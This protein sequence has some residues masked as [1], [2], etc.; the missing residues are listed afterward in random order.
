VTNRTGRVLDVLDRRGEPVIR[1]GPDATWVN[2]ASPAYYAEHPVHDSPDAAAQPPRWVLASRDRSWGW[3]DPRIQPEAAVADGGWHIDMRLGGQLLTVSG[4]FRP[5]AEPRGYW[6]PALLTRAE[7]APKVEAAIVP[8]PVPAL[9]IDNGGDEPVTIIGSHGE[10]F[11]RIGPDGVFANALSPTW[12]QS[13]RAPETAS[14][15]VPARGR[16]AV[17]WTKISTGSR[18]TWLEWRA[19]GPDDRA[20]R[21]A[22][23]WRIP[24][25]IGDKPVPLRG[26]SDWIEMAAPRP[27]LAKAETRAP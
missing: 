13:G 27:A 19:R 12:L 23:P 17:R 8:G 21:M 25:L 11:L 14:P 3:F 16:Q 6:R 22:M 2:A 7:I 1:I 24:L 18:Y 5:H 26:E 15:S 20:G 4:R 9:T 10:K